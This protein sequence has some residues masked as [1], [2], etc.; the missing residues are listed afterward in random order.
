MFLAVGPQQ[1]QEVLSVLLGLLQGDQLVVVVQDQVEIPECEVRI[2]YPADGLF[3]LP[4]VD[5][6]LGLA[7]LPGVLSLLAP[8]VCTR[9]VYIFR[10]SF[11]LPAT[12][13]LS[14]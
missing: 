10:V 9:P 11:T 6:L 14:T 13:T 2:Q 8:L 1:G 5:L 7:G 4:L 3:Q 12:T